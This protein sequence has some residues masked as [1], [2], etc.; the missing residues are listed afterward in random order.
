MPGWLTTFKAGRGKIAMPGYEINE[1]SDGSITLDVETGAIVH[2]SY[3]L[4]AERSRC[5]FRIDHVD[6]I[7]PARIDSQRE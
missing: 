5:S 3:D 7:Q 2:E 1:G 4:I 6:V